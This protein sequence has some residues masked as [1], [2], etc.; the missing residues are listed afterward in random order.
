M[1]VYRRL[2]ENGIPVPEYIYVDRNGLPEGAD[3]PGFVETEDYVSLD[4]VRI[5]RPFVEKPVDADNH[6]IWIYYPLSQVG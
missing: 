3:P 4:G 5:D 2:Q 1:Q 6:N